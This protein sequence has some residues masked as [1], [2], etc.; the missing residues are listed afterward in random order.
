ML[1]ESWEIFVVLLAC[2]I[3]S[4]REWFHFKR[5]ISVEFKLDINAVCY[6]NS[7]SEQ[8]RVLTGH[9]RDID[10]TS[11]SIMRSHLRRDL[12]TSQQ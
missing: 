2:L 1:T 8:S 7:S 10:I 3:D 12:N 6:A 11:S 4:S 5:V 9:N